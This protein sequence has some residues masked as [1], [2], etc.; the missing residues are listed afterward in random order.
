MTRTVAIA[1][2][3]LDLFNPANA[4]L[5]RGGRSKVPPADRWIWLSAM[6]L[7]ALGTVMV[8]SSSAMLA[9]RK[10]GSPGFFWARQLVWWGLATALLIGVSRIDHRKFRT[11]APLMLLIA[12]AL[13]VTARL[14][15]PIKDVHRW[16]D[17]GPFRLQPAEVF[18]LSFVVY[19][20]AFLAKRGEAI[21]SWKSWIVLVGILGV[22]S[23]LLISLPEFSAALTLWGTSGLLLI[24][25]GVRWRHVLPAAGVAVIGA[26]IVVYGIGYKTE[27]VN[28]WADGLTVTGGMYQVQQ[29]KYAFGSGGPLG[30]GLG[31]GIA[32]MSY[33]PE[34]HTDFILASIGE[35][36]GFVGVTCVWM[37]FGLLV[38]R[39][40][41]AA[42][43]APDRFGYLLCIGI[44]ASLF[45]NAALNA[46]VAMGL[47]PVTGLPLPL[48]SYGGSSLLCTAMGWGMVLNVS[49]FR[50]AQA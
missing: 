39:G 13:V 38:Y 4:G 32:K 18:R 37:A 40:W 45:V 28:Q 44:G 43:R 2:S 26:I 10:F 15:P 20:A 29:S 31:Q 9:D 33:L 27:R 5:T 24:A 35:E 7:M 23:V 30:Q 11:W 46:S 14:L 42:M 22:G 8:L 6:F 25:A 16:I 48:V 49:R 21:E 12:F 34:P 41:R 47:S 1:H 17:L 19:A 3:I 50:L 36:L